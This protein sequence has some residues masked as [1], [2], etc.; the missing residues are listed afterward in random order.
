MFWKPAK[1]FGLVIGSLILGATAG[2]VVYLARSTFAQDPGP[3][4]YITGLFLALVAPLLAAEIYWLYGLA[5]M[6]YYLDRNAL[7]ISCGM[8]RHIVPLDAIQAVV[9][10][11]D[12]PSATAFR[13]IAWPGCLMGTCALQDRGTLVVFST[14]PHDRQLVVITEAACYGISPARPQAFLAEYATQRALGPLRRVQQERAVVRLAALP[15]W[16]D[17]AFWA[18]MGASLCAS[19]VLFGLISTRFDA[20]PDRL[21][22]SLSPQGEAFRIVGKEELYY[23]PVIG[24]VIVMTNTVAGMLVHQKERLAAW[25]L[26]AVTTCLQAPLWAVALSVLGRG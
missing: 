4:A 7:V 8:T 20:L 22:L 26:S 3:S 12:A 6:R 24:M 9:P 19:L 16:K 23:F 13:G 5:T 25:L 18:G 14:E 17:R 21:A 2:I 11:T 10:G 15:I 1:A